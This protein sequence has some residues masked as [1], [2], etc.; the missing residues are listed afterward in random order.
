MKLYLIRHGETDW[1]RLGRIQGLSDI[2]LNEAGREQARQLAAGFPAAHPGVKAVFTSPLSRA[3]E[4]AEILAGA[5]GCPVHVLPEATE[6][7]FGDFEGLTWEQAIALSEEGYR[8]GRRAEL[9]DAAPGGESVYDML[10]RIL[11]TLARAAE[12]L[13]G[14]AA[15]VTHGALIRRTVKFCI[16]GSGDMRD[17]ALKNGDY[18]E[19]PLS[20]VLDGIKR[21]EEMRRA[22]RR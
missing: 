19:L 12:T 17:P 13:D 15:L 21:L 3:R 4:T 8:A 9:S 10:C 2:P 20:A 18:R 6:L 5:M 16:P 11:P 1:N 22:F 7:S 14:D